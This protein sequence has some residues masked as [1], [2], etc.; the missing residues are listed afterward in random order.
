MIVSQYMQDILNTVIKMHRVL[1][2]TM[3]TG[4]LE[5]I[6]KEVFRQLTVDIETI[7]T[8][9]NTDTKFAKT[10]ARIDLTEI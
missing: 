2:S 8:Q 4:Q 6:F 3:E 10:R 5:V 9:I 1:S 7:F